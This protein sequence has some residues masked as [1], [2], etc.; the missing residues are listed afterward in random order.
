[1]VQNEIF[2]LESKCL[3]C[4]LSI[5]AESIEELVGL[6]EL[7][8]AQCKAVEP[9]CMAGQAGIFASMATEL[10]RRWLDAYALLFSRQGIRAAAI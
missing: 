5:L 3:S 8:R 10:S 1:V 4:S 9:R 7:H 6:E 2:S